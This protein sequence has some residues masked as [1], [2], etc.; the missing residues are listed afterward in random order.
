[1][2]RHSVAEAEEKGETVTGKQSVGN[3]TVQLKC[4]RSWGERGKL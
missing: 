4:G 1:M 3:T 2:K